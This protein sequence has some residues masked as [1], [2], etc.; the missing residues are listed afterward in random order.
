[1]FFAIMVGVLLLKVAGRNVILLWTRSTPT[2]AIRKFTFQI[3]LAIHADDQP[4]CIV[5]KLNL[6]LFILPFSRFPPP[7]NWKKNQCTSD[8]GTITLLSTRVYICHPVRPA[9]YT[10][11]VFPLSGSVF[12]GLGS[13]KM[14]SFNLTLD[15]S[16]FHPDFG[17]FI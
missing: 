5:A 10:H 13:Q 4:K 6:K 8:L 16:P 3:Q 1:M 15:A 7:I 17:L 12:S 2:Y 9:V 11:I 14:S